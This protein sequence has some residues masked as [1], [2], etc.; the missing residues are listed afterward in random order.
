ML[1]PTVMAQQTTVLDQRYG[2]F[3]TD[4]GNCVERREAFA[5]G[6]EVAEE[7]RM[8]VMASSE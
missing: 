3:D 2:C 4:L 6:V 1:V 5:V 7:E 8:T